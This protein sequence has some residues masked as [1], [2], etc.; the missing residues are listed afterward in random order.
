[1]I[2]LESIFQAIDSV[3]INKLRSSL[4]LLSIAIGVFAIIGA[5][6]LVTS[7]DNAISGEMRKAG[8]TSFIIKRFPPIQMG[9][10]NWRKYFNR[11]PISYSQFIKLKERLKGVKYVTA[12]TYTGNLTVEYQNYATDPN[13]DLMG[14]D[15]NFLETINF[16]ISK[17]R[18]ITR[19]D[20]EMN[21]NVAVIGNDV[22][23]KLFPNIDPIG[24]KIKIKNMNFIVIGVIEA[25]GAIMG[26]SQDNRVLIPLPLFLKYFA[27]SWEEDLT[28][29]IKAFDKI[30][31]YHAF[32]EAIGHMRIIRKVKPWEE[33]N[34]EIQTNE[35]ISQQFESFTGYLNIFGIIVGIF[36]L[37]AA[38]VG[39]MNIMLVS[40]KERTREIGIR[41][42]IGAKTKWILIQFIIESI[43]LS[44]LGGLV[45]IIFGFIISTYF[46]T[47]MGLKIIIPIE[48]IFF[49]FI[50][51]TIIGLIFGA[52]P[53]WKAAKL[54]PIDALRYE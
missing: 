30:S 42:A 19:E 45:G 53:A 8:E 33:N 29:S 14:G 48:Q 28:I 51:C 39:I 34:F 15:E 44:L 43:T 10:H 25:K 21:R 20:V 9:G 37:I 3:R 24:K 54:N 36:S 17:G 16:N 13:V 46:G 40:V 41:K 6:G 12:T 11:K 50:I 26:K 32:D 1:M 49:S 52:Y 22:K 23:I 7:I 35:A 31:M 47:M 4:T 18:S 2:I 38:G 5:G 27:N